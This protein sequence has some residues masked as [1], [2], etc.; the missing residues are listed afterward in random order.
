MLTINAD[1]LSKV[2]SNNKS[3]Q[4]STT[5]LRAE[6]GGGGARARAEVSDEIDHGRDSRSR[7][8]GCA[9]DV[10]NEFL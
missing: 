7:R 4:S 8:A 5:L 9:V 1:R 6:L 2:I 3:G 10:R